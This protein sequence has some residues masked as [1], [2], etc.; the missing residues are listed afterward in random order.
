MANITLDW[1]E[2]IA[3]ARETIAEGMVLLENNGALPLK[4][5]RISRSSG[6]FRSTTIRAA[7]VRA[8]W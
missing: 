5:M 6:V 7:Q 1:N 2:Y 4:K 3:A 8:A